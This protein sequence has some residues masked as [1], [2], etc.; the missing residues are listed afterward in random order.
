MT[1]TILAIIA[2]LVASASGYFAYK[3]SPLK[4]RRE[5]ER[6]ISAEIDRENA[7]KA[8]I[9]SAVHNHDTAKVNSLL[10]DLVKMVA[11][12]AII[13][14]LCATNIAC[15]SSTVYVTGSTYV[16]PCTNSQGV[17]CWAVPDPLM[18][19]I[20]IKLKKL[21]MIETYNRVNSRLK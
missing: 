17:A 20:L 19:D 7:S 12:C 3:N 15:K 9:R 16:E 14:A 11:L 5:A 18:S 8:S 4:N 21:Q 13:T 2:G 10:T 1:T 6:D